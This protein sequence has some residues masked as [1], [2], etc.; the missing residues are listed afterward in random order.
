MLGKG[1]GVTIWH[2]STRKE[3]R[4]SEEGGLDVDVRC[5]WWEEGE[6]PLWDTPKSRGAKIGTHL[7]ITGKTKLARDPYQRLLEFVYEQC[8]APVSRN[9]NYSKETPKKRLEIP[10]TSPLGKPTA[11]SKC[12]TLA[13][14]FK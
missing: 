4:W 8:A 3:R 5:A 12:A 14:T 9:C 7:S 11:A 13:I 1:L 2:G 6:Y 10:E